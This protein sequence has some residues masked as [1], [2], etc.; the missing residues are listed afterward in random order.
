MIKE[1]KLIVSNRLPTDLV[2]RGL[3][4]DHI[5]KVM[6]WLGAQTEPVMDRS[7]IE[8]DLRSLGFSQEEV[9]GILVSL[10]KESVRPQVGYYLVATLLIL[11]L[12]LFALAGCF[13]WMRG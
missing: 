10:V 7:R 2:A 13:R 6:Q 3:T 1:I 9:N 8:T 5:G 12:M 11:F 4:P